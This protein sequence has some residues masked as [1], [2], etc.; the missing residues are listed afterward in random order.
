MGVRSDG[1]YYIALMKLG[2]LSRL[3]LGDPSSAV[4]A[5]TSTNHIRAD[6]KGSTLTLY[7]NNQ[8][9]L[10]A[11]DTSFNSGHV[12]LFQNNNAAAGP[13]VEVLFDNFVVRKL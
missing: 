13:A 2:S 8:K 9:L 12:G 11:N 4:R 10:E 1:S 7:V 5:D 3:A 6:C